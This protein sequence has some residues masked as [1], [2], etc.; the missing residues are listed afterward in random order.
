[1][2]DDDPSHIYVLNGFFEADTDT[3]RSGS[4]SFRL[5]E[6]AEGKHRLRIK[7]WDVLNNSNE[8]ELNFMVRKK[9]QLVL[10]QTRVWPNPS[11]GPVRFM[12]EHNNDGTVL[13]AEIK[14]FSMNGDL[15][16]TIEGTIIA[17]SNRSYM[18]WNGRD[19]RGNPVSPGMYIYR[20]IVRTTDGRQAIAVKKLVRL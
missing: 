16:K 20:I 1:M 18:D 5:P 2:V 12:I 19:D 14:V 7:A 8:Y 15:V 9:K 6:L 13:N 3:Y 4:L 17:Y 10:G 11:A